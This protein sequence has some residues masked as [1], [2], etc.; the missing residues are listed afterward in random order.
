MVSGKLIAVGALVSVG[1][2]ALWLGISRAGNR[3]DRAD[4]EGLTPLCAAVRDATT[5]KDE[6]AAIANVLN[7]C[8]ERDIARQM[9]V[10]D[11]AGK[12]LGLEVLCAGSGPRVLV[13]VTFDKFPDAT[14]EWKPVRRLNAY[15]L[16]RQEPLP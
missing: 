4:R 15:Q 12:P 10:F 3:E 14:L 5:S 13:R 1:L 7:F 2:A 9:E 6:R 16:L 8:L 11:A